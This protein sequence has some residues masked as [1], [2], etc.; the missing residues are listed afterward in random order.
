MRFPDWDSGAVRWKNVGGQSVSGR[1]HSEPTKENPGLTLLSAEDL[2][3]VDTPAVTA[4]SSGCSVG[5]Q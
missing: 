1:G 5:S 2:E 4:H 3:T